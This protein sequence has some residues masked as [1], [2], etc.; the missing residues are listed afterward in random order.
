MN[1]IDRDKLGP[2]DDTPIMGWYGGAYSHGFVAVHPFFTVEGLDPKTCEHGTLVLSG[3]AA[4]DELDLLEWADEESAQRRIG[5]EITAQGVDGLAKRFGQQ[6]SWR[7]ICQQANFTNHCELDRALR[8][9]IGGFRQG[10]ADTAASD[11]LASYC[12]EHKIFMPNEGRFEPLMQAGLAALF[13]GAGFRKVVVGDEFGD[14]E[15]LVDI[16]LLDRNELWDGM[17]ELPQYGIKRLI[18]PDHSLLAWV[19]W[20]SFYTLI[21][22]TTES[23]HE[24][25]IDRSFEGFWCSD[26][27]DTYWLNQVCIPLIQ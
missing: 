10:L 1:K 2:P 20:D 18:A 7:T 14:D 23:L 15:R 8:T 3:H 22:G 12:A 26:E 5:K 21:L 13:R 24:L 25:R 16:N 4:P 11:R 17:A 6:I 27:T 19:H 9:K